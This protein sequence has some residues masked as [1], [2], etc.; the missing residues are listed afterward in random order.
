MREFEKNAMSQL[1]TTI[2]DLF[3]S[4]V[5][6]RLRAPWRLLI[7]IPLS[8]FATGVLNLLALLF[9][10]L[11]LLL[12][13]Q[14]PL[15]AIGDGQIWTESINSAFRQ[16]PILAG[17][18]A[19]LILGFVGL[20]FML[21]ARWVDRRPWRDYGFHVSRGWWFDFAF[22]LI[23]G[24]LLMGIIFGVEYLAGW[25]SV[26]GLLENDQP[27]LGFWQLW[28][29]G[30]C[31]YL[32]VGVREELFARG[33]LIRNVAEGLKGRRISF[34]AVVV[35]AYLLTS[36]FFG[37]LHAGNANASLFSTIDLML[38]GLMLGLAFVLTGELAIPIG[39]H[40]AWNFTQGYVFGFPV[41]GV[42]QHLSLLAT[43]TSGPAVWTGGAFGPEGGV[44][45]LLAMLLG[46]LL[47]VGWVRWTHR[48][49]A[50]NGDLARYQPLPQRAAGA[51]DATRGARSAHPA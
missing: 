16:L 42:D 22:G 39:L 47:I 26:T 6:G 8:L 37:V 33:Y 34:K 48:D 7:V 19:L 25:L 28:L 9:L 24:T 40:V 4:R 14:V 20:A 30:F 46:M 10:T 29:A 5:E 32:L 51:D 50:V 49:V 35:L 21:I 1:T 41:S 12:A 43:Q 18:R 36:L 38:A 27:D 17:L 3:L 11:P 13:G 2:S 15:G 44:I 31:G 23:L 45:G